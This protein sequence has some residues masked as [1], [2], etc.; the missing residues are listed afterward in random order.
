MRQAGQHPEQVK[1]RHILRDAKVTL[2]DWS[3]LMT[4]T[5]SKVQDLS[6]F[7]TTLHLISTVEAVVEYNVA[8]L[9]ASGQPIAT[10]KAV[11][12]GPNAAKA[13]ADNAGGLEAIVCLAILLYV[14]WEKNCVCCS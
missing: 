7:A 1:F 14:L 6:P 13:P 3:Y 9:Q 11:H 8:Q 10:I 2:A 5:P 4:K 12:I